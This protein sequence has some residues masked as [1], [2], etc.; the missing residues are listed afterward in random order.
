MIKNEK[1][2]LVRAVRVLSKREDIKYLSQEVPILGRYVDLAFVKDKYIY[3]IEFKIDNCKRALKQSK[4]H[5]LGADFCYICMPKRTFKNAFIESLAQ[6]GVGLLT[7]N[8]N[9][10]WPFKEIVRAKKSKRKFKFVWK[11][12]LS[13]CQKNFK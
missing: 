6:E 1:E 5:M 11:N 3:A 7:F 9:K 4:D 12:T 13:Y 2:Y 8:N 10:N